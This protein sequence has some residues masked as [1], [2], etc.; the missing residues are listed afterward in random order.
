MGTTKYSHKNVGVN[1]ALPPHEQDALR[2]AGA[3]FASVFDAAKGFLP[4][5][6]EHPPVDLNFKPDWK[7]VGVPVLK[8]GPG[9]VAVLTRWATDM[10]ACGSYTKSKSPSASRPHIVRKP[11]PDAPKDVDIK[12][13]GLR[14]C[15]NY[16]RPNDQLQKSFPFTANGID[17][18]AELPGYT[19]YWITDRFSMY[20]AYA[21][22]PGPSRE[23][24][25]VHTPVGL[26]ETTHGV[27]GN[28]RRNRSLC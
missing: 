2:Q 23:L 19:Y 6:A 12:D 8:W 9:A 11:P 10:L 1:P 27:W 21:L 20:N 5:L 24:L 17:E 4:A 3:D 18:L 7:H 26:I 28:E 16:R 14:V 13:C 15:G 22:H 25:A